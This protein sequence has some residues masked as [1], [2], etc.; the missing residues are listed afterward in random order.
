LI[1]CGKN[2][3]S[4][5]TGASKLACRVVE[6]GIEIAQWRLIDRMRWP[7][8]TLFAKEN[9]TDERS[10]EENETMAKWKI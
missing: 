3:L 8:R 1:I 9:G 4:S 6:R 7:A 10:K 2:P 5:L